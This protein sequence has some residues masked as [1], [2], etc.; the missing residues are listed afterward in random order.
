MADRI[1]LWRYG[2]QCPWV[3]ATAVTLAAAAAERGLAFAEVDMEADPRE[4]ERR[5]EG[6]LVFPFN[7]VVD[8]RVATG[9]PVFPGTVAELFASP[10]GGLIEAEG[11]LPRRAPEAIARLDA[12]TVDDSAS[13]CR[14][15]DGEPCRKAAWYRGRPD[16]ISGYVGYAD[17]RPVAMLELAPGERCP[18]TG[19]SRDAGTA[20]ILC[21]YSND[22]RYDYRA[23][24]LARAFDELP[25]S[26][27]LA[28]EVLC[29]ERGHYPN[30][31]KAFFESLGFAAVASVGSVYLVG[32]GSDEVF[33]MRRGL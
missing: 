8:G 19:V 21:A 29:G 4:G 33:L 12:S 17:G 20:V 30:G 32:K 2:Y 25:A 22:G 6:P 13:V 26:G 1:E 5:P 23:A 31:T 3:D 11:E 27:R 15:H 10:R 18:Y 16:A 9:S 7:V 14:N 24:L 28:V